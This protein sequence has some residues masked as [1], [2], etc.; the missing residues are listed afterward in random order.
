MAELAGKTGALY[1]STATIRAKTISVISAD[2]SF[3][4]SGG[5]F[6]SAG[7]TAADKIVSIGYDDGNNNGLFTISGGGVAAGKLTCDGTALVDESAGNEATIVTA[8]DDAQL[9]GFFN[10][11][12]DTTTDLTEITAFEDGI[13]GA[14][15]YLPT[16]VDWTAAAERYWLTNQ[17]LDSF[18]GTEKWVRF[19]VKWVATP[20]GGDPSYYY[21]GMCEVSGNS[22]ETPVGDVVKETLTFQGDGALTLVT[23]TSAWDT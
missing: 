11:T 9:L 13:A 23:R 4:D 14:K 12:I 1:Y 21:E 5:G 10:W 19:F 6:V 15:V 17:N 7:F 18:L 20:S 3:N 22:I 8:P 16:L 2:N